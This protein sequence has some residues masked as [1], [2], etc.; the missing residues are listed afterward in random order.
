MATKLNLTIPQE[1]PAVFSNAAFVQ[2]T[3][4]DIIIRFCLVDPARG[5]RAHKDGSSEVLSEVEAPT[6]VSV[7]LPIAIADG[8]K[9]ALATQLASVRKQQAQQL[10]QQLKQA[11]G[12][13][14]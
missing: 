11:E 9:E 8:L 5:K 2:N 10:K 1:S 3:P 4:T 6:V 12:Q 14:G 7:F 13:N